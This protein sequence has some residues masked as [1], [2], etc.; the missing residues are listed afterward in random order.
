MGVALATPA[1]PP[2]LVREAPKRTASQ[3]VDSA[4]TDVTAES[5]FTVYNG[6]PLCL[7]LAALASNLCVFYSFSRHQPL[8]VSSSA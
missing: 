1:D 7:I 8:R 5:L 3:K 2:C 6:C 4:V